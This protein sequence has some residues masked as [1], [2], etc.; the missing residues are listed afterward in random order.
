MHKEC[1]PNAI[2]KPEIQQLS[3]KNLNGNGMKFNDTMKA[4]N[5]SWWQIQRIKAE[6]PNL[7]S[8]HRKCRSKF[9]E[10]MKT[11]LLIQLD[12]KFKTTLH[13]MVNFIKSPYHVE[14]STQAISNL[15]HEMDISWKQ[16]TNIP[17][18]WNKSNLFQQCA[19]FVNWCGLDLECMVVFV[20]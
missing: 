5:V 2:I 13:E 19:N 14:V 8:T 18:A 3:C 16:V 9:T 10:Q 11:N 20:N 1:K 15:I 6:D 17:V 12:E 7:V 4:Y